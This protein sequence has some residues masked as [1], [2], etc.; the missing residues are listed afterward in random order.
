MD[1]IFQGMSM[2][3]FQAKQPGRAESLRQSV[4]HSSRLIV[5]GATRMQNFSKTRCTVDESDLRESLRL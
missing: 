4:L 1:M 2:S 3:L 5:C